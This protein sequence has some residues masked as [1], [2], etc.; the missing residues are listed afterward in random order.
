MKAG[1]RAWLVLAV[2][3]IGYEI[4]APTDELLSQACDRYRRRRPV[5]TYTIIVYLACHLTRVW[6]QRI[7]PL[8]RLANRLGR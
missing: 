2:G 7:D 8:T 6:P 1:D 4:A 3:V 5:T